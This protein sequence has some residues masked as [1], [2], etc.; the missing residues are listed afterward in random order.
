MDLAKLFRAATDKAAREVRSPQQQP[1]QVIRLTSSTRFPNGVAQVHIDGD[2]VDVTRDVPLTGARVEPGDRVLVQY[3]PPASATIAG[4]LREPD[5]VVEEATCLP[6]P[7]GT[8]GLAGT[9]DLTDDDGN[10]ITSNVR[11]HS[12][13]LQ[14]WFQIGNGAFTAVQPALV[15]A[16]FVAAPGV[17]N[18]DGTVVT[19][20]V[21]Y[22]QIGSYQTACSAS[23]PAGFTVA[24]SGSLYVNTGEQVW[25][26]VGGDGTG[27]WTIAETRLSVIVLCLPQAESGG[28]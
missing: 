13:G 17:V 8:I 5:P 1:G 26:G 19:A 21:R 11:V 9:V 3:D 20:D 10:V 18:N 27:G 12:V 7:G 22:G 2:P 6:V 28:D 25:L 4:V 14:D 24:G 16:S 23:A 15:L